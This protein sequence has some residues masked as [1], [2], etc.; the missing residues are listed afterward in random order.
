MMYSKNKVGPKTLP[1]GTPI[2]TFTG[3]ETLL[4]MIVSLRIKIFMRMGAKFL[5]AES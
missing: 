5:N 1:C 4:F 3:I 2:V